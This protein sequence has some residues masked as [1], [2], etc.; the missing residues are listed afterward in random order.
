M[1]KDFDALEDSNRSGNP[2]IHEISPPTRRTV[3]RR[4]A[5]T[6][7]LAPLASTLLPGCT[8]P[9]GR[10]RSDPLLGFRGVAVSTADTVVVPEGYT[11]QVIAPWGDPVGLASGS[12]PF[13]HDA[14]NSAA[15]QAAQLGMH[16]D[17][18]HYFALNGSQSGLL[19]INHEY[20]DDGL[21][22]AGGMQPWTADK[23]AKSQAAH[24]VSV[25]EVVQKAGR[26]EVVTPS[27]WARRITARTP[28]AVSGA[29]AGHPLMQ[30]E[31]DPSEL[32]KI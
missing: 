27:P 15:E 13:S 22:H 1:A 17:G 3:L 14:S 6:A 9:P 24:G 25:I 2:S 4:A 21:L 18:I 31:A 29:A 11:A 16:H 28:V 8:T 20:T 19:V 26:W 7:L 12:P 10:V 30:T 23:V 32:V 5:A